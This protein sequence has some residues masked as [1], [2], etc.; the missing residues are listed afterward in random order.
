MKGIICFVI[1]GALGSLITWKMVKDKYEA[2]VQEEIESVKK[3]YKVSKE[4]PTKESPDAMA[5]ENDEPE[6][7]IKEMNTIIEENGYQTDSQKGEKNGHPYI[8]TPEEFASGNPY[9]DK[10][11][12][13]YY[14][15]G[16]I[17]DDDG[18]TLYTSLEVDK[19]VGLKN[20]DSMGEFEPGVLYVR[21]DILQTDYEVIDEGEEYRG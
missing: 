20:L 4:K 5:I 3:E 13:T 15:S 17:E 12:L 9:Y 8:I 6:E 2:I 16:E 18:Q 11:S 10:I 1:G 14:T 19:M 7:E 21:N